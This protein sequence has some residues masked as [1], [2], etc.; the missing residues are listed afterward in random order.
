MA[1]RIPESVKN[2]FDSVYCDLIASPLITG[3]L[4]T[5]L[6]E[7]QDAIVPGILRGYYE[8]FRYG[9]LRSDNGGLWQQTLGFLTPRGSTG[10]VR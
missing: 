8:D 6:L 7:L 4:R 9:Q 10:N 3:R 5:F 2:Y 1:A